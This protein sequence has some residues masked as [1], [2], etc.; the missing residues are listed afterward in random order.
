MVA[1]YD[2]LP[3]WIKFVIS[4]ISKHCCGH[5]MIWCMSCMGGQGARNGTWWII[6]EHYPIPLHHTPQ[7]L[8]SAALIVYA[9][10]SAAFLDSCRPRPRASNSDHEFTNYEGISHDEG[11]VSVAVW[12]LEFLSG[13]SYEGILE[14]DIADTLFCRG[15]S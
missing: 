1:S 6:F 8:L 5:S 3:D 7:V 9:M 11:T 4:Y 10:E 13:N 14:G 15:S 12:T 2:T